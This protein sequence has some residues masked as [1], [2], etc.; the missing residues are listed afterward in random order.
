MWCNDTPAAS[1]VRQIVVCTAAVGNNSAENAV[2]LC[3]DM[4]VDMC[5]H[6]QMKMCM[7]TCMPGQ[8][9]RRVLAQ[10]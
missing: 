1:H 6:M 5:L 10:V 4:W 8:F 3:I 7:N 2:V 9:H